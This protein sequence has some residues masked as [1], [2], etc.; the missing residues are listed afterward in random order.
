[1]EPAVLPT[2]DDI[3]GEVAAAWGLQAPG[4]ESIHLLP[5]RSRATREDIEALLKKIRLAACPYA[6]ADGKFKVDVE[7][8]PSVGLFPKARDIYRSMGMATVMD[9]LY[10]EHARDVFYF[11]CGVCWRFFAAADDLLTRSC[12]VFIIYMLYHSQPKDHPSA[13]VLRYDIPT[14]IAVMEALARLK[15][16]CEE[17]SVLLECPKIIHELTK[18]RAFSVGLLATHRVPVFDVAGRQIE[19]LEQPQSQKE[20]EMGAASVLRLALAREQ[21]RRI[22]ELQKKS[23]QEKRRKIAIGSPLDPAPGTPGVVDLRELKSLAGDDKEDDGQDSDTG[24]IG[25]TSTVSTKSRKLIKATES[26]LSN[27]PPE[28]PTEGEDDDPT[29]QEAMMLPQRKRRVEL[30]ADRKPQPKRRKS[31]WDLDETSSEKEDDAE[32][33]A[34]ILQGEEGGG[35]DEGGVGDGGAKGQAAKRRKPRELDPKARGLGFNTALRRI[36]E[37][38]EL[39]ALVANSRPSGEGLAGPNAESERPVEDGEHQNG[40]LATASKSQRA[41]LMELQG[42]SMDDDEEASPVGLGGD[43]GDDFDLEEDFDLED[44]CG[45]DLGFDD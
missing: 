10:L 31:K 3:E 34:N 7:E 25:A 41:L 40:D 5:G 33:A 8:L 37:E 20:L 38:A 13:P 27:L 16:E 14:S 12:I 36:R 6:S 2:L 9:R 21:E 45:D 28:L 22:E 39:D 4:Y 30:R 17:R 35:D 24:S 23:L 29:A 11:T 15:Q 1:M 44:D 32:P 42:I 26:Y 19:R 43:F 18:R